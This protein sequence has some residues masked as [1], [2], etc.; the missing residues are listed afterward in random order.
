MKTKFSGILTLFLAF[1]VQITFAQDKTIS[2]VVSDE[3]GLPL[4]SATIIVVGTSNGASTNFDGTYSIKA[5]AGDKL[6][7]S[8]VGYSNNQV[9]VGSSNTINISLSPDNTLD[10]VVIVAAYDVRRTKK[11]T[12]SAIQTVSSETISG[13]PNA[14]LVQTLQGQAAGLNITT[15]S[16]QPG[17]DSEIN[18]RGVGSISGKTEPLFIMDGIPI[19]Q[20]NFRSLNPNE[21]ASVSVLKDAGATSIY[22]NRG[23]NGVIIITTKRGKKN[24]PLEITYTGITSVSELQGNDYDLMNSKQQLL[25]E[26]AVGSG[27]GATIGDA[28]IDAI[29]KFANT[30]WIDVFFRT[31]LTQNHTIGITSGGENSNSFTSIGYYD[32][33]GILKQS[34]LQRFNLRSNING[35]SQNDRFNYGTSLSLNFSKNEEPNNIGEGAVNRNYVLGAYQS[36]PYRSPSEYTVGAG[37]DLAGTFVNTPLLLLDRLATFDRSENEIKILASVNAGYKLTEKLSVN[38][39]ISADFTDEQTIAAEGPDGFN[40]QFFAGVGEDFPGRVDQQSTRTI[41]VDIVNSLNYATKIGE[42]HTLDAGVYMEYYK[43]H[44]RAFGF[45]SNGLDPKTWYA[46]DGSGFVDDNGDND[47]YVDDVNAAYNNAG[48]FSYF[49]NVD[50]DFDS[51]Y[52][53]GITGRRDASYRFSDSNKWGTFYAVS[54]RWNIDQESFMEG[55]KF[56][57]LKLRGSYGTSGNQDIAGITGQFADF[58][59]NTLTQN[60]FA[61]GSGYGNQNSIVQ[62]QIANPDLKWETT[63]QANIGVDFEVF[64]SRLR[65]TVDVY[66]KDTDDV[67]Q[68]QPASAYTGTV[69]QSVNAGSLVNKGVDLSLGYDLLKSDEGLNLTLN[70]VGNY[71]KSERYGAQ[72]TTIEEGGKLFQYYEIRYAGVNPAN[73]NL[74][75]LDANGDLTET[76]DEDTDRVFTGKNRFPDYQGS[77]GFEADYKGFYV[78][79]QFNYVIGAD[80][81]DFNY[82]GFVDPS[83]VGSFR[84]SNDLT[85]AWTPNNRYT[86]IPSLTATNLNFSGDRF[87]QSA[88]YLRLRFLSFGYNFDRKVLN[89]MNLKTLRLF[90]NAEN[91]LTITGWRGDDAEGIGATQN[92]YPT[93]KTFSIGLELGI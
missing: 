59:A 63:T 14:S 86:D 22:G 36:L 60:L 89:K 65:G 5:K 54:G 45:R 74:L 29:S 7:Y 23:A 75:F 50:Y 61:T 55:S 41:S 92:N 30:E 21:I 51:K 52:G 4:P 39:R 56:N 71:N 33:Q 11:T 77:F 72:D 15:N 66:K 10:E 53:F 88:D 83:N 84:S 1:V 79:T 38:T 28:E 57:M 42:K 85:R 80:R 6:Q 47:F 70:F 26:R 17:G 13:R 48:L 18:L 32:T 78:S 19:D 34:G 64:N 25:L 87:L 8:Y 3:N 49:A 16:G 27:R 62:S 68:F 93:P 58:S 67:F 43:A 76:P 24:S 81:F 37:G 12:T 44:L 73:G 35:N 90:A 31:A 40:S 91:F 9:T 46:G 69:G 82:S 2:G 20:D